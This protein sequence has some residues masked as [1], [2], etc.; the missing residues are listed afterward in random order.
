M[1]VSE[2]AIQVSCFLDNHCC[3]MSSVAFRTVPPIGGPSCFASSVLFAVDRHSSKAIDHVTR[4]DESA[5]MKDLISTFFD[6]QL[7]HRKWHRSINWGTHKTRKQTTYSCCLALTTLTV[8]DICFPVTKNAECSQR[9]RFHELSKK[10]QKH[11]IPINS[12]GDDSKNKATE[13]G[14]HNRM[15]FPSQ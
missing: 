15:F 2:R 12:S 9:K 7:L 10:S 11:Q 4:S 6:E 5:N 3:M 13:L 8:T 1:T 14:P